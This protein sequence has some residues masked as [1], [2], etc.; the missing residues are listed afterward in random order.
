VGRFYSDGERQLNPGDVVAFLCAAGAADQAHLRLGWLRRI[1]QANLASKSRDVR[2]RH[3]PGQPRE[4]SDTDSDAEHGEFW[5]GSV[6]VVHVRDSAPDQGEIGYLERQTTVVTVEQDW[7]Y[8]GEQE[9]DLSDTYS[10]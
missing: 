9:G 1:L 6:E 3:H 7:Y 2:F 4:G 5:T 10:G 8:L